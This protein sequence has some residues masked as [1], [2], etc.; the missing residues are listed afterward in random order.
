MM[1]MIWDLAAPR[2]EARGL[3]MHTSTSQERLDPAS[4]TRA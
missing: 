1:S 4:E 2:N 3:E